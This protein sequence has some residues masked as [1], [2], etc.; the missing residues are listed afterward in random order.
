MARRFRP[1]GVTCGVAL[2]ALG[3][4]ATLANQGQI[5]LLRTVRNGWPLLLVLW[6]A[7]ELVLTY[8]SRR[9]A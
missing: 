1:E 5:D 2:V 4:A 9:S 3:I 6:G 7:L 8:S